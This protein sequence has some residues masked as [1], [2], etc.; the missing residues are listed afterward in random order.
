MSRPGQ[1]NGRARPR[2][3]ESHG[4]ASESFVAGSDARARGTP[5]LSQRHPG[6]DWNAAEMVSSAVRDEE[7]MGRSCGSRI[8][9]PHGDVDVA[10]WRLAG[11]TGGMADSALAADRGAC[12]AECNEWFESGG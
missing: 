3:W 6:G 8:G 10:P 9:I 4:V 2:D 1:R 5:S 11:E 12:S 7:S